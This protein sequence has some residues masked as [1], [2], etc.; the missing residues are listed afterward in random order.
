MKTINYISYDDKF[1]IGKSTPE[2][3]NFDALV[4]C[5]QDIEIAKIPSFIEIIDPDAFCNCFDLKS[6]EFTYLKLT[7]S[8]HNDDISDLG[9]KK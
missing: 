8:F 3:E 9:I 4:F 7:Y 1:I 5:N 6:I 2:K